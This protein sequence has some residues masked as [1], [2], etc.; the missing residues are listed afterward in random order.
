MRA[1]SDSARR[2]RISRKMR[3]ACPAT[4]KAACK[5]TTTTIREGLMSPCSL[6]HL[7]R[8]VAPS[9]QRGLPFPRCPLMSFMQFR[10]GCE[11]LA[12]AYLLLKAAA[13]IEDAPATAATD[14][15]VVGNHK[16]ASA[17]KDSFEMCFRSERVA[18]TAPINFSFATEQVCCHCR[19]ALQAE[20]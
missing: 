19:F 6:S 2:H 5:G 13:C 15:V 18:Q 16:A 8:R 4:V 20:C 14:F 11:K 1:Q 9:L 17:E 7:A 10:D 12:Q 3:K